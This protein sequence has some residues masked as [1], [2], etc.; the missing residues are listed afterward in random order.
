M[1][2]HVGHTPPPQSSSVSSPFLVL[3]E[4]VACWQ[5][6][7]IP[8]QTWLMQSV[9]IEHILVSIHG[10]QSIPPQSWSVS[11]PFLTMS[12]HWAETQALAWHTP[13]I[14]WLPVLH[15]THLPALGPAGSAQNV[16][17]LSLHPR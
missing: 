12:P 16:P 14:H 17:P 7:G 10:P 3:S 8:L 2:S 11:F 15:S 6:F 5:V 4:H 9:F 13:D 1:S